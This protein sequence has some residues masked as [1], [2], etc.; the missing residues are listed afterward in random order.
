MDTITVKT[1][2][3]LTG[4]SRTTLWR[5]LTNSSL[6]RGES[7]AKGRTKLELGSVLARANLDV[8]PEDIDVILGA[9]AGEADA[10]ADLGLLMLEVGRPERAISWLELSAEQGYADAMQ[11]LGKLY[12]AGTGVPRDE[13]QG[14]MWIARAAALGHVIAKAQME[15]L[16]RSKA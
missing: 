1:A 3:L 14:L 15:G 8:S 13:Q 11:W 6:V 12:V 9:D 2:M 10:Q 7:D 16:K 4:E 5:G